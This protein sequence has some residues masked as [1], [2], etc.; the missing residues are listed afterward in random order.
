[1]MKTK[2]VKT[3][4]YTQRYL[5]E[6]Y[7]KKF[8]LTWKELG[9]KFGLTWSN[10]RANFWQHN[11]PLTTDMFNEFIKVLPKVEQNKIKNNST[12]EEENRI[13]KKNYKR[14]YNKSTI[15]TIKKKYG[16]DFFKKIGSIGGKNQRFFWTKEKLIKQG[17]Y[18]KIGGIKRIQN[19]GLL[20]ERERRIADENKKLHLNFK[21]NYFLNDELN[22]DFAYFYKGNLIAV[23]ETTF[24][25]FRGLSAIIEKR[26]SLDRRIPFILTYEKSRAEILLFLLENDILPIEIK[27]RQKF[28]VDIIKNKEMRD[29]IKKSIKNEVLMFLGD[30]KILSDFAVKIN[31]K[32]PFD[33]YEQLIHNSLKN[34]GLNPLG[35]RLIETKNGFNFVTD[36]MI[37][38]DGLGIAVL[39]SVCNSRGSLFY[40]FYNHSTYGLLFSKISKKPVKTFSIIFDFSGTLSSQGYNKPRKLWLKYCDYRLIINRENLNQ[41]NSLIKSVLGQ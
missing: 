10:F 24:D 41:L 13:R 29:A 36:N 25:T 21:S 17:L 1:M 32:T 19:K 8:K 31:L 37:F 39:V 12:I 2:V 6:N 3:D 11:K 23:E 9:S 22:F 27:T 7:K 5:I 28:V 16:N 4:P 35:R 38:K 14:R 20:D 40:S 33:K 15:I 18:G 34:I 30:A 26:Q